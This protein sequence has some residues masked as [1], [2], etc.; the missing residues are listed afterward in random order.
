MENG[1]KKEQSKTCEGSVLLYMYVKLHKF[2]NLFEKKKILQFYIYY[3][4]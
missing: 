1:S 4:C 2:D 3:D